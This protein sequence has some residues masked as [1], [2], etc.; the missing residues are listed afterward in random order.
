[1]LDGARGSWLSHRFFERP[2]PRATLLSL[3]IVV[4]LGAACVAPEP[5]PDTSSVEAALTSCAALAAGGDATISR[6]E[7]RRNFGARKTL[8]VGDGDESLLSFDLSS[9]PPAAAINS[10]ALELYVSD[11]DN[12]RPIE[13][14]R[15]TAPWTESSVTFAS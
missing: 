2:S 1:M 15:A 3:S 7:P 13:L 12:E 11:A 14:H 10:A 5:P 4:A 8:R 9:I 6:F